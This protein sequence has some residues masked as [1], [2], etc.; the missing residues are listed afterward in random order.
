MMPVGP[1][2]PH[3][4]MGGAG[5]VAEHRSMRTRPILL[6]ALVAALLLPAAAVPAAAAGPATPSTWGSNG[7][8]ELADG[9][10]TRRATPVPVPNLTGVTTVPAGRA[11]S[12]AL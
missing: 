11:Y 10:T 1:G 2:L 6:A 12:A 8:G 3:L 7:F 4:L 5:A 9:T